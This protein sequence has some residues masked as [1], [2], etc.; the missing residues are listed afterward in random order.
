MGIWIGRSSSNYEPW[1]YALLLDEES[2][3]QS[4]A[5]QLAPIS[6]QQMRTEIAQ[7]AGALVAIVTG[8]AEVAHPR[9]I[10]VAEQGTAKFFGTTDED[11][12]REVL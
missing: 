6:Y 5:A 10:V 4:E 9:W 7:D 1:A 3:Q 8:D 11:G 12:T 2:Y